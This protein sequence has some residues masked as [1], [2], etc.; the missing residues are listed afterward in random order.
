[1]TA[2]LEIASPADQH[3]RQIDDRMPIA[4]T[5]AAA[6]TDDHMIQQS[7]I[8]IGRRFELFQIIREH[9]GLQ[10]FDLNHLRY[11]LGVAGVMCQRVVRVGKAWTTYRG[12]RLF[13]VRAAVADDDS[14]GV[15]TGTLIGTKVQTGAGF[16]QLI[17][18]Q[19]ESKSPMSA[20]DWVRGAHPSESE[21][22][23]TE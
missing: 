15:P 13:V 7:A 9:L 10:G 14:G 3:Q 16:L 8:S 6:V 12:K 22:L 1:M 21:R 11:L 2:T 18:V 17:Q 5:D 20:D 19:P 4:L 23:G